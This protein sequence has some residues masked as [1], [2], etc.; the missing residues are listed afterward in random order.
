[1]GWSFE[2]YW[3]AVSYERGRRWGIWAC[4][5]AFRWAH[6]SVKPGGCRRRF[7]VLPKDVK[8]SDNPILPLWHFKEAFLRGLERLDYLGSSRT[9]AASTSH[10][11]EKA[12]RLAGQARRK[13]LF[14]R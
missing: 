10:S 1:M 12:K 13:L 9:R 14:S 4:R 8:I 6:Y 11:S 5:A 2:K 7:R 3:Q